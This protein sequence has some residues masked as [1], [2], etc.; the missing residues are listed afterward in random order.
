[1]LSEA[2]VLHGARL[3]AVIVS[4]TEPEATSAVLG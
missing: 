4:T 2:V 3:E 1:M